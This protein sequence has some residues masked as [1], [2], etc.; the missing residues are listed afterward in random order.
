MYN[1][2]T[3]SPESLIMSSNMESILSGVVQHV[4]TVDTDTVA[5]LVASYDAG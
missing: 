3:E 4:E 5:G 1:N 2:Q